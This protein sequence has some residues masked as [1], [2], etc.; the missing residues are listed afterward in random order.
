MDK[1]I[2]QTLSNIYDASEFIQH[3]IGRLATILEPK[4]EKKAVK[5][6]AKKAVKKT[7]KT[8]KK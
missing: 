7:K 6:V 4:V 3:E 8:N 5:K 1:N 2:K